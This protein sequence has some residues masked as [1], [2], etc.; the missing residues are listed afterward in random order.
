LTPALLDEVRAG[1][2]VLIVAPKDASG[3]T[4]AS[5]LASAGAFHF[6]STIPTARAPWM[7]NWIFIRESPIFDGLPQNEVMKGD[8][9]PSLRG[10]YG[11]LVNG[12]G[13]DIWAGYGR[14]HSRTLGASIF[15]AKLGKGTI[16]FD[17]MAGA[18]PIAEQRL[19]ANEIAYLRWQSQDRGSRAAR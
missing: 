11:L 2:P 12:P 16:L 19:L 15:T 13:V 10:A 14:D 1:T 3:S 9:Q 7:G 8:Y 18:A 5:L 6:T 4:A 17:G